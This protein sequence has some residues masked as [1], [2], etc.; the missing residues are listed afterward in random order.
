MTPEPD[1]T[2]PK[3]WVFFLGALGLCVFA[4]MI[5]ITQDG[6]KAALSAFAFMT[7]ALAARVR[8]DLRGEWYYWLL[9]FVMTL[10]HV[11][12]IAG[13]KIELPSPTIQFAPFVVIDFAAIVFAIFGAERAA[14]SFRHRD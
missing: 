14:N 10:A 5:F 8:W 12:L 1:Y 4:V 9:L 3:R 11:G 7:I 6:D 2:V 13:T